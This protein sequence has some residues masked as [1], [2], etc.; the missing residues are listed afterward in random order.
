LQVETLFEPSHALTVTTRVF[1]LSRFSVV[2]HHTVIV[3]GLLTVVVPETVPAEMVSCEKLPEV[4][5]Q[6]TPY[7][8]GVSDG[9]VVAGIGLYLM[10]WIAT[11][12]TL[13]AA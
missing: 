13:E 10:A 11:S 2:L 3:M 6:H 7:A 9:G 4:G 1:G 12:V 8:V 5:V